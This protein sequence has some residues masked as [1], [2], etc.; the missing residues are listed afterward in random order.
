MSST[1]EVTIRPKAAPIMIPTAMSTTLPRMANS[2]NSFHISA[3]PLR[4]GGTEVESSG[5]SPIFSSPAT[6]RTGAAKNRD[7]ATAG[8]SLIHQQARTAEHA[9]V[10]EYG[11]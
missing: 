7:P 8:A 4:Q 1:R 9:A 2:L 5:D 6:Y 11:S 10:E 3:P